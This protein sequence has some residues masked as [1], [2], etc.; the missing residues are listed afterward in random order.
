M[1]LI[2]RLLLRLGRCPYCRYRPP[3]SMPT[4]SGRTPASGTNGPG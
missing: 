4:L 3:S 1:S 2:Q